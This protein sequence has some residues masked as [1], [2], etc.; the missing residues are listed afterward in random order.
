[1]RV[2]CDDLSPPC[3]LGVERVSKT[4]CLRPC[5]AFPTMTPPRSAVWNS[6]R[7]WQQEGGG[8][9]VIYSEKQPVMTLAFA[10]NHRSKL[11][12]GACALMLNA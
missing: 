9:L 10:F 8:E 3:S 4:D 2:V 5:G 6:A 11:A 7:N 1:M 12:S